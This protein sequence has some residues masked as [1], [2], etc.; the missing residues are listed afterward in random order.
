GAGGGEPDLVVLD[1]DDPSLPGRLLRLTDQSPTKIADDAVEFPLPGAVAFGGVHSGGEGAQPGPEGA[2]ERAETEVACRGTRCLGLGAGGG[3]QVGG[4][5]SQDGDR[6]F[7]VLDGSDRGV[8]EPA[9]AF[10]QQRHGHGHLVVHHFVDHGLLVA[11]EGSD[12]PRP[13]EEVLGQE[14]LVDEAG[15]PVEDAR[16][17][18][19]R[20]LAALLVPG[21]PAGHQGAQAAPGTAGRVVLAGQVDLCQSEL[22]LLGRAAPPRGHRFA[23]VHV[24][25][26]QRVAVGE[27]YP[28]DSVGVVVESDTAALPGVEVTQA[29]RAACQLFCVG[30]GGGGGRVPPGR[31]VLGS[32]SEG[33]GGD[34]HQVEQQGLVQVGAVDQDAAEISGP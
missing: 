9:V 6:L 17:Y 5:V 20:G 12:E 26:G 18:D 16:P 4:E 29:V 10:V 24:A 33:A 2:V 1:L 25:C 32:G 15:H 7:G 3:G 31:T 21:H 19:R 13:D 14:P 34:G 22:L 30:G 23:V 8:P 28:V 27:Q 11:V